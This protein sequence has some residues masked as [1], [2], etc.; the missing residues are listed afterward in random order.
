MSDVCTAYGCADDACT[1]NTYMFESGSSS[2]VNYCTTLG[3]VEEEICFEETGL[4]GQRKSLLADGEPIIC[5]NRE[6]QLYGDY[7]CPDGFDYLNLTGRCER[8]PFVC[9]SGYDGSL[10]FGCDNFLDTTDDYW[11]L[12]QS[13]CVRQDRPELLPEGVYDRTCCLAY[14]VN[15]FNV[16]DDAL[17]SNI[18]VY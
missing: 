3:C 9:D 16:Y 11:G 6:E 17:E 13:E 8:L 2:E 1:Y 5:D 14:T 7:L 18:K 15:E 4:L 10:E 12:Y